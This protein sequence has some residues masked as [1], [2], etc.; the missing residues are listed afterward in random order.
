MRYF[1]TLELEFSLPS[2]AVASWGQ[3]VICARLRIR[4]VVKE[5]TGD[6]VGVDQDER[7]EEVMAAVLL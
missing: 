2:Y 5:D 1:P 7:V 4:R 6:G 3:K